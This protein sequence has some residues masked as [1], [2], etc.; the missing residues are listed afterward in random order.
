MLDRLLLRPEVDLAVW[1]RA[2]QGEEAVGWRAA[3]DQVV[4][5]APPERIARL[6]QLSVRWYSNLY[7]SHPP[8]GLRAGMVQARPEQPAT[9]VLDQA[10]S[11]KIDGELAA[12]YRRCRR[13]IARPV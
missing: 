4:D 13:V 6:R 5:G 12:H 2:R 9:V 3:A 8:N 1:R 11:D 10:R 7:E